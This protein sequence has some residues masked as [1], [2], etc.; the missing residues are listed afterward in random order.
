MQASKLHFWRIVLVIFMVA[1]ITALIEL[2]NL[3]EGFANVSLLYLLLVFLLSM[4]AGRTAAILSALISFF[5]FLWFFVEPRHTLSVKG[6]NEWLTLGMFLLVSVLTGHLTARL[7]A[8]EQEAKRMQLETETLASA[9]WAVSSQ[10]TT[11]EALTE[12]LKQIAKV[13]DFQLAAIASRDQEGKLILRASLGSIPQPEHL[14]KDMELAL[15]DSAMAKPGLD[16]D[17]GLYLPLNR[18]KQFYFSS[19]V[20]GEGAMYL[21]LK[22]GARQDSDDRRLVETLLNHASVILHR[23]EL[24][25][26]QSRVEA[27]A[28]ADVLKTALLA[29]VTHDFRSPITGIKAAVSV[30]QEESASMR[31]VENT[32]MKSLLQGIELEVDRLNR[33]VGNILD[34]SKLE[35][36]AWKPILE[37]SD[38]KEILGSTLSGFS[39]SDNQRVVLKIVEPLQEILVDP[40]QIEQVLKNLVENALKYSPPETSVL[41]EVSQSNDYTTVEVKDKGR[42]ILAADKPL[43]FDRF[44]RA[45]GLSESTI[46][47]VGVGL[48]ICKALVE[49]H[50][51]QITALD[52]PGGGTIMR[53]TLPM[54]EQ[55]EGR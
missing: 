42:G 55:K 17:S 26:E 10:L 52:N 7:K 27:L 41:V 48:T 15:T 5:A 44:Y 21:R 50:K 34:M 35:A 38:L 3:D 22:E 30:L 6:P 47:G 31:P 45:R 37:S 33:M 12:V 4:Y 8:S 49:A 19:S 1:L 53:V 36:D 9:S 46:A 23:E 13:A 20:S 32:E 54:Q 39:E 18:H 2:L 25:R 16:G 51:G 14:L 11:E 24:T 40:V 43:I 28:Q 29:M